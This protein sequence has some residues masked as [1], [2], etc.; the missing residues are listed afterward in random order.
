[1]NLL[2][3]PIAPQ[4]FYYSS[5]ESIQNIKASIED[6]I[7]DSNSLTGKF[8]SEDE[9]YMYPN[10]LTPRFSLFSDRQSSVSFLDGKIYADEKTQVKVTVKPG[11]RFYFTVLIFVLAIPVFLFDSGRND[12]Y[13]IPAALCLLLII[14][15]ATKLW[16]RKKVISALNLTLQT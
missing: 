5:D 12:T 4:V 14:Q 9:F 15:Y 13:L 2:P 16:L 1:M 7:R 6:L 8:Y 10:Y 11:R 3:K